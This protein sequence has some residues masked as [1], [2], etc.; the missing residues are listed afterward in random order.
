MINGRGIHKT[1]RGTSASRGMTSS[2]LGPLSFEPEEDQVAGDI[3]TTPVGEIVLTTRAPKEEVGADHGPAMESLLAGT[4]SSV[5]SPS[6]TVFT[7]ILNLSGMDWMGKKLK[8]L[9]LSPLP[10][11]S[12]TPFSAAYVEA[13]DPPSPLVEP[14]PS[15]D[16]IVVEDIPSSFF[17]V[18][19]ENGPPFSLSSPDSVYF[20]RSGKKVLPGGLGKVPHL[21]PRGRG[22][23]SFLAKAH[24]RARRDLHEGKQLSIEWAL[25][26]AQAQ[27]RGRR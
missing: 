18:F 7:N 26:A 14:S 17:P 6:L 1:S 8:N 22:R 11:V 13:L 21:V 25:R 2:S 19:N 27:K 20:L 24:S 23:T 4:S 16:D 5:P 12:S 9:T 3:L 15:S 10:F